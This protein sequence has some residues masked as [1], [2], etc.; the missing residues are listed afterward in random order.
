MC[1]PFTISVSAEDSRSH[2]A[3]GRCPSQNSLNVLERS[4]DRIEL[5]LQGICGVRWIHFN[6]ERS[7]ETGQ[8]HWDSRVVLASVLSGLGHERFQSSQSP[9]TTCTRAKLGSESATRT[10]EQLVLAP[11]LTSTP[12]SPPPAAA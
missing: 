3:S 2:T 5:S 1:Y 8:T 9:P 7:Q 12:S 4:G 11:T 6:Q 10:G